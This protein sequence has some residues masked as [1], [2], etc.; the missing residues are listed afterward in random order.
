[1]IG[2]PVRLVER[3][4]APFGLSPALVTP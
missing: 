3:L 4:L 1:V 2:L